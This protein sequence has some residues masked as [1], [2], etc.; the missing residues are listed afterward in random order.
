LLKKYPGK[1][2][3]RNMSSSDSGEGKAVGYFRQLHVEL[4]SVLII[5][6]VVLVIVGWQL[7]PASGGF[8]SVDDGLVLFYSGPALTGEAEGITLTPGGGSMLVL[9]G[10]GTGSW[11]V[12]VPGLDGGKFCGT[13]I[14]GE[15]ARAV[16]RTIGS[17]TET[18]VRG[19][20]G[21]SLKLCWPKGGVA[22]VD[23]AYL[24]AAFPTIESEQDAPAGSGSR[25][26]VRGAYAVPGGVTGYSPSYD[27]SGTDQFGSDRDWSFQSQAPASRV[28]IW[29]WSPDVGSPFGV[30]AVNTNIS[31]HADYLSFL[32]GLLLGVAAGAL[33][34][35]LTEL[36]APFSRRRDNRTDSAIGR[37]P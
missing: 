2:A 13:D 35:I 5:I 15:R 1:K 37:T 27:L 10:S 18:V 3:A 25:P 20:N 23:G 24:S 30:A 22:D 7:R 17:S 14:Q 4:L 29:S 11:K 12:A 34:S 8:P 9:N 32:S 36:V 19:S 31:Q 33:I 21:F 6:F 26:A 28:G 16:V